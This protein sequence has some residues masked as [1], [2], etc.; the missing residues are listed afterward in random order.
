MAPVTRRE[1]WKMTSDGTFWGG[2]LLVAS[3]GSLLLVI[4]L[5]ATNRL[6]GPTG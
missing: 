4:F 6:G 1:G 3:V 5:A 2:I